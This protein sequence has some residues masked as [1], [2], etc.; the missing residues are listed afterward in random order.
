MIDATLLQI[1]A[2]C[3]WSCVEC[4]C[5][6]RCCC[7]C[8]QESRHPAWQ[9]A[10]AMLRV[11]V[12]RLASSTPIRGLNGD[13]LVAAH[14]QLRQASAMPPRVQR[15]SAAPD[16]ALSGVRKPSARSGRPPAGSPAAAR[17]TG[18]TQSQRQAGAGVEDRGDFGSAEGYAEALKQILQSSSD[19]KRKEGSEAYFKHVIGA[20]GLTT[21]RVVE[22][23]AG[24]FK[25]QQLGD[26]ILLPV[27]DLLMASCFQEDKLA[28]GQWV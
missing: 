13:G 19:P 4:R 1:R 23:V 5:G 22:L 28:G 24:V 2:I 10:A 17:G 21:P 15:T 9:R 27:A 3:C 12:C 16:R 7:A 14:H 8:E 18:A 26:G 20:R 6:I 25:R 11:F